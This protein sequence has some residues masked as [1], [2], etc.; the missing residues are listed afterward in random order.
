MTTQQ[1]V[2]HKYVYALRQMVKQT[3]LGTLQYEKTVKKESFW[4]SENT[5]LETKYKELIQIVRTQELYPFIFEVSDFPYV[6]ITFTFDSPDSEFIGPCSCSVMIETGYLEK[7]QVN[8]DNLRFFPLA[9]TYHKLIISPY[10]CTYST[11]KGRKYPFWFSFSHFLTPHLSS[12]RMK[13]EC[14]KYVSLLYSCLDSYSDL[15]LWKDVRREFPNLD[16]G[17]KCLVPV[18]F[19]DIFQYHTKKEWILAK[20]AKKYQKFV[21]V[22]W[23]KYPLSFSYLVL[24][25]ARYLTPKAVRKI[26]NFP[27]QYR[28]TIIHSFNKELQLE[29]RIFPIQEQ[30][31]LFLNIVMAVQIHPQHQ[32]YK[33]ANTNYLIDDYIAMFINR[34]EPL[35]LQHRTL[36]GLEREHDRI[37]MQADIQWLQQQFPKFQ[38]PKK[39]CFLKLRDILPFHYKWI[40]TIEDLAQEGYEMH[41]CVT[42]Y[43]YRILKDEC[44]IYDVEINQHRYCIEFRQNANKEYYVHQMEL[45]CNRGYYKDDVQEI[46]KYGIKNGL[47]Y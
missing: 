39:S 37:A 41:N 47:E 42:T 26:V 46:M 5:T 22:N 1:E 17:E 28:K 44:A 16:T 15:Y 33:N 19:A 31:E 7:I 45:P 18:S 4:L 6:K 13:E 23:N 14:Q 21:Q 12:D 8:E 29:N 9:S 30:I 35:T 2:I 38:I 11:A 34:K 3:T 10:R 36:K 40:Q 20:T 32:I 43:A 27:I 24:K 25:S